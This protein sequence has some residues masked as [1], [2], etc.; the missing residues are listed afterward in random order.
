MGLIL[1]VSEKDR[2][3]IE[4]KYLPETSVYYRRTGKM[5]FIIP[6][7]GP[8][9]LID[10]SKSALRIGEELPFASKANL[11][12]KIQ[13]SGYQPVYLKGRV[14][15]ID[16]LEHHTV[17]QFLPFGHGSAYNSFQAKETLDLLLAGE[18]KQSSPAAAINITGPLNIFSSLLR[19]L[20]SAV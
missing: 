12:L 6:F 14:R 19:I 2:R 16:H 15:E 9:Q 13:M 5:N 1:M 11:E 3:Y 17:V 8:V 4:R 18:F 10:I 7:Q 20:N